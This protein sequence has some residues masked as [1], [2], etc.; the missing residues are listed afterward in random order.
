MVYVRVDISSSFCFH[1]HFH[2]WPARMVMMG[3]EL[4]GESP[5]NTVYLHG[6]FP[7]M[8][9][10][11]LRCVFRSRMMVEKYSVLVLI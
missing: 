8:F 2:V 6:G 4:T 10:I 3:I 11:L 5:F 1:F 7:E 9:W